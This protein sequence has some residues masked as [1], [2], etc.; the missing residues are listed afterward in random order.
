MVFAIFMIFTAKL[1]KYD[2]NNAE[3]GFLCL[4]KTRIENSLWIFIENFEFFLTQI[5]ILGILKLLIVF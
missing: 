2:L 3:I 5:H 1:C 4:N